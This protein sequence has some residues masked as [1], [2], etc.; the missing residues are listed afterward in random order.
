M[1]S[2]TIIHAG[3]VIQAGADRFS[4]RLT[5][6]LTQIDATV[7]KTKQEVDATFNSTQE[8]GKNMQRAFVAP[9]DQLVTNLNQLPSKYN[10][11]AQKVRN[12]NMIGLNDL[13]NITRQTISNTLQTVSQMI[14]NINTIAWDAPVQHIA[15]LLDIALTSFRL[16]REILNGVIQDVLTTLAEGKEAALEAAQKSLAQ[17][18]M[19]IAK[20][21]PLVAQLEDLAH[22]PH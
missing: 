6:L 16:L 13:G 8:V 21:A 17:I 2:I 14:K 20:L 15:Q 4:K 12:K 22:A 11:A 5:Q 19:A 10:Q 18:D 7:N 1:G 9:V 3:Q